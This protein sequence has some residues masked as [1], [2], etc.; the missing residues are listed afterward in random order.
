M[1]LHVAHKWS[2]DGGDAVATT[3]Y[4]WLPRLDA[5]GM[6]E[7]MAALYGPGAPLDA[8]LA[9]LELAAGR[10]ELSALQFLE[11]TED[12]NP[13]RSFDLNLYDAR[14]AVRD[15]QGP[16]ARLREHFAVRPGQFQALYDRIRSLPLGHVAGGVHRNG[17]PFAT[18]YYGVEAHG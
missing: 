10:T 9:M 18:V 11:V 13:R 17:E 16:L 2:A 5:D 7:R 15:A 8:A 14:L 1:L 3:R 12:G 4:E 6:R